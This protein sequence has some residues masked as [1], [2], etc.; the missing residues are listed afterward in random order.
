MSDTIK[1]KMKEE[2]QIDLPLS[3]EYFM[4]AL[5]GGANYFH[6]VGWHNKTEWKKTLL[7]IL[8]YLKTAIKI[9]LISDNYHKKNILELCDSL[10]KKIQEAKTIEQIN[11]ACIEKLLKLAFYLIGDIPNHWNNKNPYM[12]KLWKLDGHRSL[13]FHQDEGQKVNLILYLVDRTQKYKIDH[14][15]LDSLTSVFYRKFKGKNTDFLQWFKKEHC[16]VYCDIF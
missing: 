11:I 14:S 2:K 4:R 15:E 8:K 16:D 10:M 13:N 5:F 12:E 9:N 3:F 7:K 1:A 6:F